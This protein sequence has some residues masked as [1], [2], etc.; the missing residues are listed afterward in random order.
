[1]FIKR[2]RHRRVPLR[3]TATIPVGSTVDASAGRVK[4]VSA[5]CRPGTTQ[6][7]VFYGSAFVVRQNRRSAVT[8]LVLAGG[9]LGGCRGQG[10]SIARRRQRRLYGSA[11]GGFI[12]H[13]R[14]S[15]ATV[16][17]TRWFTEDTCQATTTE[18]QQGHIVVTAKGDYPR[19]WTLDYPGD[20]VSLFCTTRGPA[21][22]PF[23]CLRMFK[24]GRARNTASF[25]LS[26]NTPPGDSDY[27][28]CISGP[29]LS[30]CFTYQLGLDPGTQFVDIACSPRRAGVLTA[31]W[32]VGG[33]LLGALESPRLPGRGNNVCTDIS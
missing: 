3:G 17:G 29:G 6:S 27:E 12:T 23:Y 20:R 18:G 16:R 14:Y 9:G 8:D 19:T 13:G 33:R 26:A 15:A 10:A 2:P 4:L 11:H 25:S 1:V 5:R 28:V 31:R 21:A 7:G 32:R 30:K 22:A 24:G